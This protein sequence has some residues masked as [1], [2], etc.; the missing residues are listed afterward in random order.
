MTSYR[1]LITGSRTWPDKMRL[2]SE[3]EK[4]V[5]AK[6]EHDFRVIIVHGTAPGADSMAGELAKFKEWSEERHPADWEKYGRRAG[7]VRN[8]EMVDLG[9]DV[10][11][12]FVHN[13]SRGASMTVD[14]AQKAGI[15][16][17]V[18]R[19]DDVDA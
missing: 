16:T 4:V 1:I 8:K 2:W 11:I 15:P 6:N 5:A 7:F 12:G 3:I 9:A 18:I 14:L 13:N 19:E 10:C 17:L